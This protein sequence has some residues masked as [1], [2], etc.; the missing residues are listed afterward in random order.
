MIRALHRTDPP[1]LGPYGLLARLGEGGMGSVFL[2]QHSTGRHLAAVK[3]IRSGLLYDE[4]IRARFKQE[5]EAAQRLSGKHVAEIF[6]ADSDDDIPWFAM[7]YLPSYIKLSELSSIAGPMSAGRVLQLALNLAEALSS[8]HSQDYIHRDIKPDN[9][10]ISS[11]GI[12]LIDFGIVRLVEQSTPT[13]GHPM[14]P[15]WSAPEQLNNGQ[16]LTTKVDIY[17]WGLVVASAAIGRNPL[18]EEGIELSAEQLLIASIREEFH[19]DDMDG[20]LRELVDPALQREPE[21][22]PEPE[23]LISRCDRYISELRFRASDRPDRDTRVLTPPQ[24]G[25]TSDAG[26]AAAGHK[27]AEVAPAKQGVP[28]AG[29]TVARPAWAKELAV[30]GILLVARPHDHE[31]ASSYLED[32]LGGLALFAELEVVSLGDGWKLVRQP[33][34]NII[35]PS[36]HVTSF[37]SSADESPGEAAGRILTGLQAHFSYPEIEMRSLWWLGDRLEQSLHEATVGTRWQNPTTDE[38]EHSLQ[39]LWLDR[40]E[41]VGNWPRQAVTE[42]FPN[43][44]KSW[45]MPTIG[46]AEALVEEGQS[47][48]RVSSALGRTPAAIVNK[49]R[50]VGTMQYSELIQQET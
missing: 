29:G 10:L 6:E 38:V 11:Q 45:R 9:I 36:P 5:V 23:E 22:R 14:T 25:P 50:E 7:E 28:R 46:K 41:L 17:C 37:S 27:S 18:L 42:A 2:A 44:G 26:V 39:G 4:G 24:G 35:C 19:L 43:H 49:L 40:G 20:R 3:T 16:D 48:A 1:V 21:S 30:G 47:L 13:T 31:T 15:G 33:T 12:K 8:L 34:A 32:L